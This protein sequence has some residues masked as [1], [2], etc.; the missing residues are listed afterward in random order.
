MLAELIALL[1][2]T[3][4]LLTSSEPDTERLESYGQRRQAI[5]SRLIDQ[6]EQNSRDE[7]ESLREVL[8][9][10]QEQDTLLLRQLEHYRDTCRTELLT[11]ARA[12]QNVHG[13]VSSFTGR[14]L[15]RRI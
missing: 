14:L 8:L 13:L 9:R 1:R 5:F 3:D 4:L 11:I 7:A 6:R 2:E 15:E 10:M 12:R